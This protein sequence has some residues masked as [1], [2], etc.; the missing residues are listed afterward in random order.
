ME[1]TPATVS[2][3]VA[4]LG[5]GLL[6]G[7]E[8]ERRKGQGSFRSAAGVRT[9]A[10]LSLSGALAV[11]LDPRL[12]LVAALVVGAL[13]VVS[14]ARS[15][16]GDPGVTGEVTMVVSLLLGAAA[17]RNPTL[18][19]GLGVVVA[20]LLHTKRP[21][22]RF[23]REVLS[24]SELGDLL[25]LAA[26]ILVIWPLLPDRALD[27]WG[28][29]NPASVWKYV[30]LVMAVGAAGHVALRLVG[31]RW[32][33]PLAGFFSGFASSTAATAG[34][35]QRARANPEIRS[36]AAAAALLSNL[37]SHLL[38][39]VVVG[40]G[41]SVLLR[42]V[43]WAL[44]TNCVVLLAAS[45]AGIWHAPGDTESLPGEA[46]ARAFRLSW[47]LT[48]GAAIALVL[49]VSAW[50][51]DVFGDSGALLTAGIAALAE[52]HAAAASV[53]QLTGMGG[54]SLQ[55]GRWGIVG[56]LLASGLV[57]SAVALT[58][59]GR[60]YGLRVTAGLLGAVAA[61][62]AVVGLTGS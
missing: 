35:G 17:M 31:A 52:L 7:V 39:V 1:V 57:K 37:A 36:P 59:G 16:S 12:L 6:I 50:L 58:S 30:V 15:D 49:F 4:A 41:S 53:A 27:P 10:L 2:G 54:L 47:A 32:G 25:L 14:Y 46:T 60:R 5:I 44:A 51:Q 23:S 8:R 34:F 48:F 55:S 38:F 56:L 13:A 29:L 62:G 3:L 20:V 42:S 11:L 9:H 61:A 21:L 18:A 43:G 24:Q 28:A 45:A 22:H 19:S 33:L 40:A 26:A